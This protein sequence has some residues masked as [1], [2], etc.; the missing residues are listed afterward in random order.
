MGKHEARPG[1]MVRTAQHEAR[2][3]GMVRT[4]KHA[5]RPGGMERT[6][7]VDGPN[8][9]GGAAGGH[10]V[11]PH[12]VV[13][14]DVVPHDVPAAV[15]PVDGGLI[16]VSSLP[17]GSVRSRP[18]ERM[19][20]LFEER[21]DRLRAEG[22]SGHLAVDTGGTALTYGELDDRANQLARHLIARGARP[23]DRIALLFDDAV[24][25]YVSMLAVLKVHAAYVPLDAAF[26]ADRISYIVADAGVTMI[27]TLAQLADRLL[28]EI[29]APVVCL[30][31]ELRQVAAQSPRRLTGAE[32]GKPAEDLAY[33]IYTSGSTGRPKGVAVGHASICNFVRVAADVYG[34]RTDDRIYQ[35]MTIAFDFCVEEIWVPWMSGATLV[36]KPA[37]P[38]LLGLDLADFITEKGITALCCVPTL[39]ATLEE[40][41]PGLRF[42]LVSGE[43]CPQDLIVR[44]HR[45]GR[46]F[47]NVYGPTEATV[48]ATWGIADPDRPVTLGKPLPT[49]AA[50]ILDPVEDRALAPG[51]LGEIGL[52]GVGLAK[53]YVNRQDLTDKAFIPDFLGIADNPSHRIYRTGDLGRFNDDR[54]IEYHGR[55]DMQVKIR[56]YRIEVTEIESVLL[57]VPGIALAVV[58]THELDPGTKELVAYYTLR[59]DTSR[60]DVQEIR[61]RLQER[62]PGYMVPAYF[63]RLDA[64]PVMPSGKADRKSLPAPTGPRAGGSGGE[65]TAPQTSTEEALAAALADVLHVD[66]VSTDADFFAGLGANSLLMAHFCAKVRKDGRVPPVSMREIYVNPTIA[67]LATALDAGPH[68]TSAGTAP[69]EAPELQSR[70]STAQY[71]LCGVLQLALGLGYV[72]AMISVMVAGNLWVIAAPQL[73]E[74]GGRSVVLGVVMFLTLSIVPIVLKWVLIGRWKAQ[75]I[76]IWSL[77]YLRFWFVKTLVSITPMAMFIG[78]PVYP[79]YLRALG[80]KVGRN[81]SIFSPS[82][83]VC[84]DLLTIGDG[85]VIRKDV[86]FNCYRARAGRIQTGAVTLGKNVLI[87]EMTF[88]DIDTEMGDNTAL[89][90]SSSLHSAQRV[91]EGQTWYGSPAQPSTANYRLVEPARRHSGTRRRAR[92]AWWTVLTRGLLASPLAV[93][94]FALVRAAFID[95]SLDPR[96]PWFWAGLLLASFVILVGGIGLAV[97]SVVIVTRLLNRFITAGKTYPLYGVHYALQRSLVRMTNSKYLLRLS[98]DSSFVVRYLALVGYHQPNLVQSGSNVGVEIKHESAHI[99]TLGSGTMVADGLSIINAEYSDTS[100]IISPITIGANSYFGNNVAYPSGA[101][102]GDNCLYGTKTMVPIDGPLRENVGLLGSPPFEIPRSVDSDAAFDRLKT[103]EELRRRLPAKNR[104]NAWTLVL[105]LL[106]QWADVF[107]GLLSGWAAWKYVGATNQTLAVLIWG[108]SMLVFSVTLSIVVERA[109]LGFGRLVPRFCSIYELPFWRH[110]RH[111]K[112]MAAGVVQMFNGTPFKSLIWRLLGVRIGRQVF[113]DGCDITERTLATIGDHCTLNFG[114]CLQSHSMEEGAF[115]LDAISVGSDVTIGV[116]GF[117]HYG[118]TL[119][120][121]AVVE[122]DSFLMKGEEVPANSVFGGNPAREL[123]PPPTAAWARTW[124]RAD[125]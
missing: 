118:T 41:L 34:I 95:Y 108:T 40:D 112:L 48:T 81:V 43:A 72:Y 19:D 51:E 103:D 104:H 39:L 14:H 49:Y 27:L 58:Q 86:V 114:S 74:K 98:G 33:I 87:G 80:A 88:L 99:T 69:A 90:H 70:A 66:R 57:E 50:V 12:D 120:D 119:H 62:L 106:T 11:V 83:P 89:G 67:S 125:G 22:Q 2:P 31:R 64:M 53:G 17:E 79:F 47:L 101:R 75:E 84:T 13:P 68:G 7:G 92:Y 97:L 25:S 44:W 16:L 100:F 32:K 93:V 24:P 96:L 109:S 111:W 1:S 60:L 115:K 4:A 5:A 38:G 8:G 61:D 73:I 15:R 122:A 78:T 35:G 54:E 36:P 121:G 26:P 52:A 30:D 71:V 82:V 76:P 107:V 21:C 45:P 28:P 56:G 110:E 42:L 102:M 105:F 55:I 63:E 46:R 65:Y 123:A 20:Q 59:Q 9:V 85:T 29:A 124:P 91:P 77:A 113:D 37:G 94:A 6:G 3:G 117:I 116:G 23:G 18:G 10:D